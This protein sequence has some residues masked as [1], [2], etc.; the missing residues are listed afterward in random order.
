MAK[1]PKLVS[2]KN[3]S[4]LFSA[5]LLLAT[6]SCTSTNTEEFGVD[7]SQDVDQIKAGKVLFDQNCSTCH[8]FN[9]N[10][11]GPN[12]SGLTRQ[13]EQIGSKDL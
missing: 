4:T 1:T 9:E 5:I 13:I 3:L 10:A 6:I 11:I 7:I 12:L 2:M 8:N